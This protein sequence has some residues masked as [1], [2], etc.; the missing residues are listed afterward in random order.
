MSAKVN[1]LVLRRPDL[2]SR[3][4]TL[5]DEAQPGVELTI[6]LR[7][8]GVAESLSLREAIRV[9]AETYQE[10]PVLLA[11]G[12]IVP[13]TEEVAQVACTI[14]AMQVVE[15]EEERYTVEEI[16]ALF[17]LMPTAAMELIQEVSALQTSGPLGNLLGR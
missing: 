7:A 2:P 8:L 15:E 3:T 16:V 17:A 13:I 1:L 5:V 9:F 10:R 11:S 4:L 14:A 12:D 6:R